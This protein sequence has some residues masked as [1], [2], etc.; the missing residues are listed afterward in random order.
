MWLIDK[1]KDNF[2]KNKE[3]EWM[4]DMEFVNEASERAYLKRMA[5]DSV[6]N[7]VGRTMSTAQFRFKKDNKTVKSDWDYILNVR[8]GKNKSAGDFWHKFFYRLIYENEVLVILT[9][10]DDLLIADDYNKRKYAI[11]DYVFEDVTV[12][13]YTFSSKFR[14]S[15]V[16]YLEY[17]NE[18]LNKITDGLFKDYGEL[19]GRM[20][21][22]SMRNNQIRATVDVENTGTV[23]EDKKNGETRRERLQRFIDKLY[24]SVRYS[25]VS[26]VPQVKGFKYEEHTNKTGVSNQSLEDVTKMK[27][28][29]IDDVSRAVGVPSALVHGEMADLDSNIKA[30]RKLCIDP[31]I[32]KLEDELNSKLLTQAEYKSGKRITIGGVLVPDIFE[33]ATGIDKA[34]GSGVFSPND[35]LEELGRETIDD[36]LMD[37]HYITK[38]YATYEESLKGGEEDDSEDKD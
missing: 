3:I 10:D 11:Y 1:I 33:M 20:I 32:K 9:D 38:N 28:S 12:D 27:K 29:L 19:F 16:I 24:Q 6:L 13:D 4:F 34:V 35:V 8:T 30:F 22:I 15:E 26:I 7:F 5:I 23:N 25:S 14:M 2:S 37:K 31:L 36:P 18:E 17:N 21:E